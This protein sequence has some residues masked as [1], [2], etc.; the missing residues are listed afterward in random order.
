MS[1]HLLSDSPDAAAGEPNRQA[2]NTA[3]AGESGFR[4]TAITAVKL[5]VALLVIAAPVLVVAKFI[6]GVS[7]IAF[8]GVLAAVF[9]WMSGGP[10]IGAAVVASLSVLGV[11][12]ILLRDHT[13]A[14]ALILLLLGVAYGYAA[15]WGMGKA[16]L[17]LPILTPYFMSSP[18][19]LFQNPPVIDAKYVLGMVAVMLVTGLWA[20]LVL[21]VAGGA[22]KLTLGEAK[23]PRIP[24]IYGTILGVFSAVVMVIGTTTEVK[25]HW[26]WI[27]LTLYVLADPQQLFTPSKMV[28]RVLGTVLG[29]V[30]VSLLV[31]VGTP[32]LVMHLAALG[33]LWACMVFMVLRKPYWEYALFLTIA[34][35]LMDFSGVDTLLLNAERMGFTLVG[36]G[37]SV[38]VALIVNL[39]GYRRVGLA[40]PDQ[41]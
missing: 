29:F 24:I 27:T 13:W 3:S 15:S 2:G 35:I 5:L 40:A 19:P 26:V 30:V 28:G 10:K 25:T 6:P 37:I 16:V 9:G 41:E 38:A 17:Q 39:I 18:P 34:V 32:D 12:S 4:K 1:P 14:L 7:S 31:L 33:A 22:R 21:H 11:V 8:F 23:T 20:L 36:A